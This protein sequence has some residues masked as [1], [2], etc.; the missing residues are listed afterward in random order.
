KREE[1]AKVYAPE[2][3]DR[4]VGAKW[5]GNV[6]HLFNVVEQNVVLSPTR[7]INARL[8]EQALGPNADELLSFSRA[9]D[10]FTREYLSQ[11]LK[12]TDGNVTRAARLAKRNRTDFYK[13]LSRFQIDPAAFK[14][15]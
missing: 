9:R 7:V 2:A 15:H 3:M 13:L 1:P 4:L 8:V 5:P 6:R 11:L 10:Q 14:V 12:I